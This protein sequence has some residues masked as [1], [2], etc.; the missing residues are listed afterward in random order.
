MPRRSRLEEQIEFATDGTAD[1]RC[2]CVLVL[3]TSGSMM[4]EPIRELNAGLEVFKS[5]LEADAVAQN[6]VEIAVV[7]FNSSVTVEHDFSLVDKFVPPT[8]VANG[9][10]AMGAALNLAL[11]MV[12]TR[13]QAY[14]DN[15]VQYYR[16]WV[17]LITD[18]EPTDSIDRAVEQIGELEGKGSLAF[19]AIGVRGA[20]MSVL[21]T[22][23]VR[24][25]VMLD[26]LKF[27][28]FFVWLSASMQKVSA[29]RVGDQVALPPP[30]GWCVV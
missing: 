9:S 4:G 18:G 19:F 24:E 16:P 22:F 20:N 26:G 29:S 27:R 17:M 3:D 1:P 23:S 15:G 28:E 13:K 10:T 11:S 12:A 7:A 21:K 25:P 8:L 2:P 30:R 14:K 5:E 6:R